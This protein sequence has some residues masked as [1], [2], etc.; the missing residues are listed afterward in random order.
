MELNEPERQKTERQNYW[1]QAK[2]TPWLYLT[3]C[4]ELWKLRRRAFDFGIRNSPAEGLAG[5]YK[6]LAG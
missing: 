2:S 5:G 4:S 6:D 1:Q 3:Y